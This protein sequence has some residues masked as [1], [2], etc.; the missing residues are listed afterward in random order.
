M[1]YLHRLSGAVALLA[2]VACPAFA[3]EC[4]RPSSA[5][6]PVPDG[7]TATIVQFKEAHPAVEDYVHALEAYEDCIAARI[8]LMPA[9]TKPDDV[10]KLRADRG[11][12]MDDA[13]AVGDAYMA[14]VKIFKTTGQGHTTAAATPH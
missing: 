4:H 8:K 9:G 5:A 13:K 14:Q 2:I 7:A 10:Q 1:R 6:P 12:A 3:D 11:A